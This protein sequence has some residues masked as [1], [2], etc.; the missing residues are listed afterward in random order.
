MNHEVRKVLEAV[1]DGGMSVDEALLK[2]KTEPF[3]EI[4]Y[5]KVELHR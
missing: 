2:I 3:A 4:V 5:A 1:K